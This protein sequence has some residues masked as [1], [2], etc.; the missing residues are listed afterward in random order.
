MENKE[1]I[2]VMFSLRPKWTMLIA[3]NVK[4]IE[5]RSSFCYEWAKEQIKKFGGF[6]GYI[7]CTKNGKLL[8]AQRG[9]FKGFELI[10]TKD[11]GDYVCTNICECLNGKVVARFWC[12]KVEEIYFVIYCDSNALETD[13]IHMSQLLKSSC[14]TKEELGNYLCPN[15]EGL[16]SWGKTYGYAIHISKLEVFEKSKE[17]KEF[18]QTKRKYWEEKNVQ[19]APQ[20]WC[21]V[22]E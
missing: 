7:Y 17:L 5:V 16:F 9:N 14:L 15:K 13:N 12:D 3:N 18:H 1:N 4:T 19:K 21:Y 22:E 8:M 11:Y 10:N 2:A 6:Y 20:S